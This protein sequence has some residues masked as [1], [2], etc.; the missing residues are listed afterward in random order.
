MKTDRLEGRIELLW[1]SNVGN[2]NSSRY[3]FVEASTPH[4]IN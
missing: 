3:E 2:R 4:R 1:P